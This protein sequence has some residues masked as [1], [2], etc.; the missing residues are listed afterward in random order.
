MATEE[1]VLVEPGSVPTTAAT[2]ATSELRKL[3]AVIDQRTLQSVNAG[4]AP[5]LLVEAKLPVLETFN[6]IGYDHGAEK[7]FTAVTVS[8]FTIERNTAY[9]Y[10]F[11]QR[12]ALKDGI[13]LSVTSAWRSNEEQTKIRN[14][15]HNADG[16]LTALGKKKGRAALP[17]FSNHQKGTTLD[18]WVNMTVDDLANGRYSK[19]YLWLEENA[20]TY[21]FERTVDS[22]P[23][24]WEHRASSIVG[25][26]VSDQSAAN[27]LSSDAVAAPAM[28]AVNQ[29]VP[30]Y[31]AREVYDR[32]KAFERS[33]LMGSTDYVS[34]YDARAEESI[35]KGVWLSNYESA[36]TQATEKA[37]I[38]QPA[39]SKSSLPALTYDFS[40]GL[41]GDEEPV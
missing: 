40:R 8:G 35:R 11:M 22:E 17:K 26:M 33:L 16:S 2:P 19:E 27:L 38:E 39:F 20:A 1:E 13:R 4:P 21:G 32:T 24:H 30:L 25:P 7:R 5:Q 37:K 12:A 29:G 31:L 14:Q 6:V 23:W 36:Y 34:L 9:D 3:G 41:W 15:R 28:S 18:L 10:I